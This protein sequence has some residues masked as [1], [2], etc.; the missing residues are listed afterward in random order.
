[1]H[2]VGGRGV[3]LDCEGTWFMSCLVMINAAQI[4][5]MDF[6][7]SLRKQGEGLALKGFFVCLEEVKSWGG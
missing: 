6:F 1:M 2:V 5:N 3:I 4:W 7:L